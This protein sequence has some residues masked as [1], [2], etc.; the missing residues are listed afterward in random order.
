[1]VPNTAQYS[2]A[3]SP[4]LKNLQP[5]VLGVSADLQA[6]VGDSHGHQRPTSFHSS[7]HPGLLPAVHL[8]AGLDAAHFNQ[9]SLAQSWS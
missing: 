3:T 6:R 2:T 1:M 7:F 5:S 4:S 9:S 8:P